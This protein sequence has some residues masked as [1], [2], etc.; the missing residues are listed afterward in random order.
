[1]RQTELMKTI[2]QFFLI[3]TLAATF[4]LVSSASAQ[5]QM[6]GD[7][8]IAASPKVRQMLNEQKSLTRPASA[9]GAQTTPA[10][11]ASIGYRTASD[12]GI[13]AS[14]KVR[15]ML[16]ERNAVVSAPSASSEVAWQGYRATGADGI[17]ASPKLR[18]QLNERTSPQVFI[19]PL[20]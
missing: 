1:M 9:K 20:K 19:A 13:A 11:V 18:Q 5:S 17:T 10:A 8:G 16:N 4:T 7:D 6:A 3:G 14:P 2:N 12:D 15:Q